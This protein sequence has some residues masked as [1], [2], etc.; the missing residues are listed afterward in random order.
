MARLRTVQLSNSGA[1]GAKPQSLR[2]QASPG[3]VREG[4]LLLGAVMRAPPAAQ[5]ARSP[6]N[7]TF[8]GQGQVTAASNAPDPCPS[9]T[10][11]DGSSQ[12][13]VSGFKEK[14]KSHSFSLGSQSPQLCQGD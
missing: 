13:T 8:R 6:A 7:L 1:L 10:F 14:C 11:G 3:S 2:R 9:L 4:L 12:P 5:A